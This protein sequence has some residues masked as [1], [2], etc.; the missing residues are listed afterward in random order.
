MPASAAAVLNYAAPGAAVYRRFVASGVEVDTFSTDPRSV[1]V[2]NARSRE[3]PLTLDGA[4]ITLVEHRSAV[5]DFFDAAE[6]A[7]RY[8]AEVEETVRA[9]TGASRAASSGWMIRTADEQDRERR[10][11][12]RYLAGKGGVQPPG[13]QVHVD[14]DP[15]RAPRAAGLLYAKTFPHGPGYSRFISCSFWRAFSAPPQDWPLA[16]CDAASVAAEEGIFNPII[17]GDSIPDEAARQGPLSAEDNLPAGS[18]FTFSPS[19]RWYYYP[20]MGRDE[21]VLFKFYDSDHSVAWRVPH[22]AFKDEAAGGAAPRT[23]IE[24]RVTAYFD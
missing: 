19:H 7:A 22:T 3:A 16:L 15:A 17:F 23:S 1:E 12:G 6:V 13:N 2:C 9:L 20:D 8:P 11:T 4:G 10:R 5:R 24:F 21:A 14:Q 18:V